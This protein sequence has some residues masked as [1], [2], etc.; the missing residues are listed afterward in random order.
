MNAGNC[1]VRGA[2][3]WGGGWGAL[4]AA[5][6]GSGPAGA[7]LAI[8]VGLAVQNLGTQ[9]QSVFWRRRISTQLRIAVATLVLAR[10]G[11]ADT[12]LGVEAPVAWR[13]ESRRWTRAYHVQAERVG[14][15]AVSAESE[16]YASVGGGFQRAVR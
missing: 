1:S 13:T 8:T 5:G 2:S 12:S 6:P 3:N 16:G 15:G 4:F 11:Q 14:P 10:L 9:R 7:T